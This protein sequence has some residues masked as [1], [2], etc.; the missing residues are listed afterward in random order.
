[1]NHFPDNILTALKETV[2]NVFW[3]KNDVRELFR[4]CGVPI[5]LVSTQNWEGYK[6]HVVSP[7]LDALNSQASGLGPLRRILQETLR[8]TDGDH[9][10]WL[11]DAQRRKR[12]AERS[13]EHLRLLVRDYDA[14]KR[15]EIEDREARIRR[16]QEAQ[17]G[18][19]FRGRLE[20]L[21]GEFA[22]LCQSADL[23]GRGY[24]LERLLYDLLMLFD[25]NPRGP[26]RRTAEQIDGAFTFERDDF[27][28]EAKWQ[29]KK[30]ELSELRDLDAAVGSSLDNTLGLFLSLNGFSEGAL[31]GYVEGNR[32][33]ILC[34]DGADLMAVLEARIDMC[35][36]L[37]RKKE[38]AVQRRMVFAPASEILKGAL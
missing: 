32:P 30:V 37:R 7:V 28:V 22:S 4:R 14:A 33:R 27:L 11:P 29:A 34:M 26:F 13:L 17:R 15:T 3:K 9:L 12:E 38:I 24:S 6:Y 25:L 21:R 35:D 5:G 20:H 8:Y 10:L 31:Q 18:A 23:Q 2:V 19:A 1:M 36:L 16:V